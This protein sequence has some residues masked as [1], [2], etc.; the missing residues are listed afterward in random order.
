[1]SSDLI[2]YQIKDKSIKRLRVF[3][4]GKH[5]HERVE[6]LYVNVLIERKTAMEVPGFFSKR[7]QPEN[8]PT[9]LTLNPY[10]RIFTKRP[11]VEF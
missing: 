1:M 5:I 11:R 2:L 6:T 10:K 4:R 8:M 3:W 7:G 9:H